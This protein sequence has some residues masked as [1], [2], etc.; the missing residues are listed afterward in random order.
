MKNLKLL[1]LPVIFLILTA[2][3]GGG[4]GGTPTDT[5]IKSGVFL[6]S[7][8]QGLK[9]VSDTLTGITDANGTFKYR[10]GEV[11]K[12]YI[13]DALIGTSIG[14]ATVTPIDF[15][16]QPSASNPEMV[17]PLRILQ[18]LDQD[19]DPSNGIVLPS[20]AD[21][22]GTN[23]DLTS[24]TSVQDFVTNVSSGL[25][26]KTIDSSLT[27]FSTTLESIAEPAPSN[28]AQYS[29][30][31]S[32][33]YSNNL[34]GINTSLNATLSWVDDATIS[35]NVTLP[36]GYVV[37]YTGPRI[38]WSTTHPSI[39][40]LSAASNKAEV[41]VED[42]TSG[43]EYFISFYEASA[44]NKKPTLCHGAPYW[45]SSLTSLIDTRTFYGRDYG[46]SSLDGDYV[47]SMIVE[48][49]LDGLQTDLEII[50][51]GRYV[52]DADSVSFDVATYAASTITS[53]RGKLLVDYQLSYKIV[54]IDSRGGRYE[55]DLRSI[56]DAKTGGVDK[57]TN[58]SG[59]GTWSEYISI[60]NETLY[61]VFSADTTLVQM[62]WTGNYDNCPSLL[63]DPTNNPY[64]FTADYL[65][66]V[67]TTIGTPDTVPARCL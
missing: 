31:F 58:T 27:H 7:A 22:I 42:V 21:G 10:E 30:I 32:H 4:G 47:D 60:S 8:V 34:K 6:D 38:S 11:V 62:Y 39:S 48:F 3:G 5:T 33:A 20:V 45:V 2:C 29:Y 61:Y 46:C 17:N 40:R 15:V 65:N 12:F 14:K 37:N 43:I 26:F 56:Y 54:A 63:V 51:G 24:E 67:K 13:N 55:S 53:G 35:F 18:T 1:V 41:V 44:T 23:L 9:Y 49:Y 59:A 16:R 28:A 52:A 36:S 50:N 66:S 57:N 19:G 25:V 64:G